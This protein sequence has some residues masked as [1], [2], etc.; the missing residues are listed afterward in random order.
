[1]AGRPKGSPN[2][3]GGVKPGRKPGQ[4]NY[5]Q[6]KDAAII[7]AKGKIIA[8]LD[9]GHIRNL[10]QAARLLGLSPMQ[11]YSWKR[12]DIKWAEQVGHTDQL[13]ADR[14]EEE[15]EQAL[16]EG[17]TIS[18]PY[19]TARIFRLKA[20]RPKI[21]K[22]NFKL[23]VSDVSMKTLLTDLRNLGKQEPKKEVEEPLEIPQEGYQTALFPLPEE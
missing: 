21:Y 10:S 7:E 11:L 14:L 20:L 4:I 19:V 8:L 18:M 22:D 3:P 15:L 16:V 6:M 1:M 23:E 9:E 12:N 17:K 5:P 13:I 2:R